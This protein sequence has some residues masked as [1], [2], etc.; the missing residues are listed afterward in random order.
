MMAAGAALVLAAAPYV[1]YLWQYRS[2]TPEIPAQIALLADG[3]CAAGWTDLP[4]KS[5]PVYLASFIVAFVAD[6]MPVLGA[7]S[8]FNYAMAAAGNATRCPIFAI[9]SHK[10]Q[11]DSFTF[12]LGIKVSVN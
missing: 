1:I 11:P 3:A 2:P 9:C 7:R 10:A 12:R 4:R 5:F 8:V 6:W